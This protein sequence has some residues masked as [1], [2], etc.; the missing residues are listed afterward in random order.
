MLRRLLIL[1][2]L[3]TTVAA[4]AALA[5]EPPDQRDPCSRG[6]RDSCH[7]TGVGQYKSYRYGVRWFGD[8]RGAIRGVS[9]PAFCLDLRFWYPG[10]A[11]DFAAIAAGAAGALRNRDGDAV[12]ARNLGRMSYAIWR[13]GHTNGRTSQGAVMLYV[14]RMMGDG[15]PGEVDP[16]AAGPAVRAIYERI[17]RDAARYAGP[18]RVRLSLPASLKLRHTAT[19]TA[20]VLAASGRVV[21]GVQVK[22]AGTGASGLPATVDTGAAA[23]ARAAFTPTDAKGGLH[24]T[25][26]AV[27]LAAARPT[28]YVPRRADAARNGQRLAVGATAPARATLSAG[29]GAIALTVTTAATPA[30]LLEGATSRDS[31]TIGGAPHDWSGHVAVRL[32]GPFRTQAAISCAGAPASSTSYTAGGGPSM[33]PELTPPAPGWY[34]YQL[35][36]S[37]D[38]IE[39]LTT[40]CAV[41]AESFKVEVQ[42]AIATQISEQVAYPGAKLTDA[43]AVS[44][45]FG[46][47]ATV[48]ASLYG[49]YPTPEAMT[50]AGTPLW[51]G[52][53]VATADGTTITEPVTLTAPGYYTYRESIAAS[54]LVRAAESACA[55]APETTIVRGR[56]ALAT[57]IST[58]QAEPGAAITDAVTVSGLG[59]LSATVDVALYG[60][61]ASPGEIRCD[62]APLAT[63]SLAVAGDGTFTSAPTTLTKAGYYTYR[64]S[65]AATATHDAASTACA[66]VAET[67]VVRA[68]PAVRT[69]VSQTVVHRGTSISDRI[70]VSG[71]GDTPAKVD[72]RLYG[73][74]ASLAAIDCSG[75]PLWQ[76]TVDVGGDG[77]VSSPRVR[78]ARAGFYTYRERIAATPTVAEA[79]TACA[80]TAETSLASPL[81]LT[82]RGERVVRASGAATKA[83]RDQPARVRVPARGI[84]APV[85]GV[86]IDTDS[87]AL[88]IPQQ[89]DRVGWWRDGAVPGSR[90][91][92]ILLAGHVDSAKR[93]AGAFSALRRA[94]RGDVVKVTSGDGTTRSYTI[95]SLL[96]VRKSAL[97]A[98]IFS[99]GGRRRLVLVTCG[100]PFDAAR[101]HY[102]DNVIVTAL[103]R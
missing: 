52:S 15:A 5:A 46:E 82:G 88:A 101:G 66:E 71:L 51:T 38:D 33:T 100:G 77:T 72:V 50:C 20:R 80:E 94:R 39:A 75:A 42:P 14:H 59:V 58:Q 4:P 93:G 99:R 47:S 63:S 91:G 17:A 95:S 31:V 102:R 87:G 68:H 35:T 73:P 65:L 3:L 28:I 48:A 23:V 8:Y 85:Y 54:E 36:I 67:T 32:Y 29:V 11:Y 55:A 86:G 57:Q 81:I 27:G 12:S 76:G 78:L 41:A 44:G 79:Q 10:R 9:N 45:L 69:V 18:Y 97:P 92:A 74:Y 60:P 40:P 103:P 70:S 83:S 26:T 98:S 62:G 21:P 16:G 96:H 34:G 22:L 84:D 37:G 64:E 89:I 25:A 7:T 53:F 30:T 6:G 13:F 2:A 43:V 1:T 19:L 24:V 49:P 90:S 56:P 61:F